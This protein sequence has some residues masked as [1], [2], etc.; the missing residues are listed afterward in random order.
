[1]TSTRSKATGDANIGSRHAH[2]ITLQ[3]SRR[4][5]LSQ[6]QPSLGTQRYSRRASQVVRSLYLIRS[7]AARRPSVRKSR[8]RPTIRKFPGGRR[9]ALLVACELTQPR[10]AVIFAL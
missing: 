5:E 6:D 9:H 2:S 4:T 7:S 10:E 8:V 1:M 3:R